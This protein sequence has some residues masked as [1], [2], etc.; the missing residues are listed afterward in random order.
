M[1]GATMVPEPVFDVDVV[2]QRVADER[3]SVLPG[4]PTIFQSILDHPKRDAFDLSSLR[5]VV[6]GAAVVPVELVEAL[7][8]E[9]GIETVLTAYGLTEATGTVTMCRRGDSAEVISATSGRAIPDVEV[10]I[11][12][13]D[14]AEVAT[15]RAGRDRGARLQRDVRL[16]PTTPRPPRRPST[17]TAGCTPATSASST[18]TATWPSPTG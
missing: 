7:R 18:P 9:L 16:L 2:L 14:G 15:G 17:P 13:A 10:R 4:P 12:D 11:V 3:I 1:A 5:L 8:S 6:T